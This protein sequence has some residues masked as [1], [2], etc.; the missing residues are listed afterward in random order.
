MGGY[1]WDYPAR[2][3]EIYELM[4]PHYKRSIRTNATLGHFEYKSTVNHT[5]AFYLWGI[6]G[7]DDGELISLVIDKGRYQELSC[8]PNFFWAVNDLIKGKQRVDHSHKTLHLCKYH[9]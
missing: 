5:A 3:E 4:L 2:N 6:E 8:I 7:I 9:Q 1:L